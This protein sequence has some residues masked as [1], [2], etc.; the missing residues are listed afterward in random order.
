[1]H[2]NTAPSPMWRHPVIIAPYFGFISPL[3]LCTVSVFTMSSCLRPSCIL[4]KSLSAPGKWTTV[5]NQPS[6]DS[7]EHFLIFNFNFRP[8]RHLHVCVFVC[9][10]VFVRE[11]G[12]VCRATMT[13]CVRLPTCVC[14]C[15]RPAVNTSCTAWLHLSR[16]TLRLMQRR[17]RLTS[18]VIAVDVPA[19]VCAQVCN[20]R[21]PVCV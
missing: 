2:L 7:D 3:N 8:F 18:E 15:A 10:C 19:R 11:P 9:L 1:M 13:G 6:A 14:V 20:M 12:W 21:V 17:L 5:A 16:L 4:L